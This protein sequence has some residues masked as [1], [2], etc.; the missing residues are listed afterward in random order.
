MKY[1]CKCNVSK[2]FD[3]FHKKCNSSDGF[4]TICKECKRAL[5]KAYREENKEKLAKQFKD[6]YYK[7]LEVTRAL[8]R[9]KYKNASDEAKVKRKLTKKEYN[10]NLPEHV[11]ERKKNYDKEYF[12]SETGK[13]VIANSVHKRRAQK[14]SS[15]DNTI[16]SQSLEELK[17]S[18]EYLCK[19]CGCALDFSAK[20]TVHLDHVIPLSKGGAHSISNVVWSCSSCNLRKSNTIINE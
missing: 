1:C 13:L 15:C 4:S 11:K 17:K 7:D 9:E 6:K 5:D 14:L 20:G 10:K 2:S 3:S 19:Y 12:S 18:Q 16:T 8:A